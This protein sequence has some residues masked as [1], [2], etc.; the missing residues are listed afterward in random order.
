VLNGDRISIII[1]VVIG[2]TGTRFLE[3]GN[4]LVTSV[5]TIFCAVVT[6]GMW[7]LIKK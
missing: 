3:D 6:R 5:I 4:L 1:G 2:G 7:A